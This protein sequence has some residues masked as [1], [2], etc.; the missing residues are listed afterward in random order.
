MIRAWR[1]RRLAPALVDYSEG[2]LPPGERL[3]I[4]RHLADCPR[5]AATA[6]AL[7]DA[8]TIAAGPPVVRDES[9]WVAQR[10]RVMQ[11]IEAAEAS[12]EP[13]PLR[14]FDWRL[15]L[16]VAAALLIAIAGYLSLRPPSAPGEVA[17][18]ALPSG[19]LAEL[20]EVAGALIPE[21]ELLPDLHVGT[22]RVVAGAVD[23]GW[24]PADDLP[25][26]PAWGELDDDD[27][28]ALNGMLG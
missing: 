7:A 9:F 1:C 23:A 20:V 19:D 11:A 26:A 5:C 16:P 12:P 3:E 8:R 10:Q 13:A 6:A 21:D 28:D 18:D 2:G 14:G 4:E 27:L 24:V 25:G 17:L 15:A 22:T